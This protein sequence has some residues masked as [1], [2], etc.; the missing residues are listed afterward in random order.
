MITLSLAIPLFTGVIIH[1]I[2]EDGRESF[3]KRVEEAENWREDRT[4]LVRLAMW[5]KALHILRERPILG[6]G[7]NN[8]NFANFPTSTYIEILGEEIQ[9][10][11]IDAHNTYLNII[12]GTG[13]LGVLAYIY[14]FRKV[15]RRYK[16]LL[17]SHYLPGIF[18]SFLVS[19][20]GTLLWY[21]INTHSFAHQIQLVAMIVAMSTYQEYI[22]KQSLNME[23]A[24]I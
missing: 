10:N 6:A 18:S 5:P 9:V 7:I 1:L 24:I 12:A 8:R 17:K 20:Y 16:S 22:K 2:S 19:I 13:F 3:N 21:V 15:Y 23:Q 4:L 14:F 11:G